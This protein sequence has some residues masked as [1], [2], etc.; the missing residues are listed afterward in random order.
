M[1]QFIGINERQLSSFIS[2]LLHSLTPTLQMSLT[3][4]RAMQHVT[5]SVEGADVATSMAEVAT[6]TPD[7]EILYIPAFSFQV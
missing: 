2:K 1:A 4:V 6:P 5:L 7:P 3:S